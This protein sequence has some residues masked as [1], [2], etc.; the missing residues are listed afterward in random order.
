MV[1]NFNHSLNRY[2]RKRWWIIAF[3]FFGQQGGHNTTKLRYAVARDGGKMRRKKQ[4][5]KVRDDLSVG[6]RKA[7]LIAIQIRKNIIYM[8]SPQAAQF[9]GFSP[10][11]L[12]LERN[13]A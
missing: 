13:C 7:Y 8:F 5:F 1:R 11:E 9:F 6:T 10:E 12:F 3:I 2:K 4:C